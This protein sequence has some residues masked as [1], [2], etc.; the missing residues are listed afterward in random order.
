M[1]DPSDL[2]DV[3][4]M[5][6]ATPGSVRVSY[7]GVDGYGH[8]GLPAGMAFADPE[9]LVGR[10]SVVV[11]SCYFPGIGVDEVDGLDGIVDTEITVGDHVYA[12]AR[13]ER[14]SEDGGE[15]FLLLTDPN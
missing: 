4:A 8:K 15:I 7:G 9:L 1:L 12:I 14:V 11:A 3:N 13:A 6:Q 2:D 10:P 5:I